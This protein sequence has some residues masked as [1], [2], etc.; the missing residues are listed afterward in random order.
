MNENPCLLLFLS[1]LKSLKKL[2]LQISGDK[3]IQS[4][5]LKNDHFWLSWEKIRTFLKLS[6]TKA[7]IFS[8]DSL[9]QN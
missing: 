7:S 8:C 4:A 6:L 1:T 9:Q 3:K 2:K 5:T